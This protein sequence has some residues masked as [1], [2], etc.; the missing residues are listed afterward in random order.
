MYSAAVLTII[1][2]PSMGTVAELATPRA[3]AQA[4]ETLDK[5]TS[6]TIPDK[7]EVIITKLQADDYNSDIKTEGKTNKDGLPIDVSALGSNVRPLPNV[8]FIAYKIPSDMNAEH[9]EALKTK[10]TV[11]EVDSYLDSLQVQLDKTELT[12][13]NDKGQTSFIVPKE[14]NGKYFIV[15][16]L[17][18]AETPQSISSAYAVPFLLDLPMSASDGSGYL[19][20]VNVYPKNITGEFP[21][22]GKDVKELG[23]NHA[24]YNIGDEISW[25]MKGTVPTNMQDYEVYDFTDIIDKKLDFIKVKNVKYGTTL[26]DL[27]KDYEV[28][29]PEKNKGVLKVSL[30]PAGITKISQLHNG[31][32]IVSD[33]E[34]KDIKTNT[35]KKPFLQVE[36]TTKLNHTAVLGK[37]IKN[38]IA[39]EFDNKNDGKKIPIKTPISDEPDVQTGGKLFK[40]VDAGNKTNL[41]GAEFELRDENGHVIN[42]TD[43]LIEANDLSMFGGSMTSGKPII[44]KSTTGTFGIRGLSYIIKDPLVEAPGNEAVIANSKKYQLKEIK[45]P[46]GY[47]ILEKPIEFEVNQTSYNSKPTEIDTDQHDVTPQEIKNTKR[48]AIPNTGGIGTAIFIAIGAVVMVFAARGMKGHNKDK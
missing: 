33:Q 34:I 4:E 14:K 9:I 32:E 24:S 10:K 43:E 27:N 20:K 44:L 48:P 25:F 16:D 12:K 36:F 40:K 41:A 6:K 42:W 30:T 26:L 11:K 21:K 8:S 5:R 7:T 37:Q 31:R 17:T 38:T 18:A 19:T 13:T 28:I 39:I 1:A 2:G 22:P 15:E 46:E 45:A 3:A 23:I 35:D 29:I 47:V